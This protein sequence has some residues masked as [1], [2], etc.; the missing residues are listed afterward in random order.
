MATKWRQHHDPK[1][2]SVKKVF[3]L[4]KSCAKHNMFH[5]RAVKAHP[6]LC[7]RLTNEHV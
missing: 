4:K 1:L 6:N 5:I 7:S 3:Q 2:I